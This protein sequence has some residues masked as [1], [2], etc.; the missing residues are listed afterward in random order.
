MGVKRPPKRGQI[1]TTCLRARPDETGNEGTGDESA[2]YV[3]KRMEGLD[4]CKEN[5][6]MEKHSEDP[7]SR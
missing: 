7:I 1:K 4:S 6:T 5:R 2:L 3:E